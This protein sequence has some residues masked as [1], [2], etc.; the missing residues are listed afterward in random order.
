MIPL[1]LDESGGAAIT[2]FIPIVEADYPGSSMIR[3]I[4]CRTSCGL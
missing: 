2:S 1:L 4:K 3:E